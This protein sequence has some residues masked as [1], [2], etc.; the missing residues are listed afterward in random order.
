MSQKE[1]PVTIDS[2]D[3]FFVETRVRDMISE[4]MDPINEGMLKDAE[5]VRVCKTEY[6][7]V[8]KRIMNLEDC[9]FIIPKPSEEQ[10]KRAAKKKLAMAFKKGGSTGMGDQSLE[11]MAREI[12]KEPYKK[13]P[14][15]RTK[16]TDLNDRI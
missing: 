1:F 3:M 13:K 14:L 15:L 5:T 7:N 2:Y 9:C 6:T 4:Y 8:M 12:P 11:D 10:M 16:F